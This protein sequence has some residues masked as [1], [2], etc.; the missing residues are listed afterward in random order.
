MRNFNIQQ[1]FSLLELMIV[2][3]IIGII[4]AIAVP[5]YQDYVTSAKTTE[6]T[7]GLADLRVRLEQYYQDNRTY[8]GFVDGG[9]NFTSNNKPAIIAQNFSYQCVTNADSYRITA[10]G[11]SGKGMSSFEYTI[12]EDNLRTSKTPDGGGGNDCWSTKKGHSC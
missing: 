8:A 12:D 4:S 9:C 10:T 2:V 1:G 11:N 7:S 6:A 5:A 3:A